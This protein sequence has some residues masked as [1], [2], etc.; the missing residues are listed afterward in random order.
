MDSTEE[1]RSRWWQFA[2][3]IGAAASFLCAIHCA[4]LPF[5]LALLPLLGLT[6]LADHA[7][8]RGFVLF[9]SVL[10][11]VSLA[12]GYR[13]HRHPLPLSFALP[14]LTLLLIGVTFAESHSIAL[15]SSLVASG[16]LLVACAHFINLRLDR[17]SGHLHG[18]QC[19]H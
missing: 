18:P 4:A 1:P 7:F 15:H 14:G 8:E 6:F 2:D 13:R 11:L 12:R 16:G 17:R 5:V 3:R 9:A 19:A 10:A